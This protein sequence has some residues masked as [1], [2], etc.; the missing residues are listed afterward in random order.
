MTGEDSHLGRAVI[1]AL[2]AAA[3]G[4]TAEGWGLLL[5][6][7]PAL[8]Q[9]CGMPRIRSADIAPASLAQCLRCVCEA[10][11]GADGQTWI[12][13]VPHACGKAS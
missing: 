4:M 6:E 12:G 2:Q 3:E 8:L 13:G 11:P 10:A 9:K 7:V 1:A 5:Q